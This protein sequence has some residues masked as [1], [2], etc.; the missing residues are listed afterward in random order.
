M[1]LIRWEQAVE[2]LRLTIPDASPLTSGLESDIRLK[3]EIAEEMVLSYVN[4][5][6]GEDASSEWAGEVAL[7][8]TDLSGTSPSASLPV[9]YRVQGAVLIQLAELN[10]YR[11][12]DHDSDTARREIGATLHPR[13]VACLYRMRDPA[14]A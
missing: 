3:I 12:D 11:G 6:I 13:A 4:Q 9:P 1:R 5:R 14:I 10:R 7:W 2:H 8:N